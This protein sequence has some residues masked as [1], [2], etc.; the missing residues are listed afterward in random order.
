M[1]AVQ[2]LKERLASRG[3]AVYEPHEVNEG[4]YRIDFEVTSHR[5]S[6]AEIKGAIEVYV[7]WAYRA[8]VNGF[9]QTKEGATYCIFT[10]TSPL[11]DVYKKGETDVN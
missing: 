10:P 9:R 11:S 7:I 5:L 3:I 6:L 1:Q 2:R 8:K 4:R